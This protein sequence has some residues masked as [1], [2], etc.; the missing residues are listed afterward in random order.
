MSESD[1][2]AVLTAER[3]RQGLSMGALAALIGCSKTS[4]HDWEHGAKSPTLRSLL[5]WASA[6]GYVLDLS[7]EGGEA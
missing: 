1:Y 2:I 7:F 5:V 6:L 3:K 4:I